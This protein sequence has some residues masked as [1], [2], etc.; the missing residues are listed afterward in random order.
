MVDAISEVSGVYM[1]V[2]SFM[3]NMV[4]KPAPQERPTKAR[5]NELSGSERLEFF[6][7]LE[8]GSESTA[9]IAAAEE[10]EGN[11]VFGKTA[12]SVRLVVDSGA[13]E[14]YL[15]D[16]PGLPDRVS[17]YV[18]LEEPRER[19]T[20]GNHMLKEVIFRNHQILHNRPDKI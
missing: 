1:G 16:R 10:Y 8:V 17:G 4:A 3:A 15:D 7:A 19:S 20:A 13:C 2:Y 14:Y 18:R 5:Q 12:G 6:G 11:I 9:L